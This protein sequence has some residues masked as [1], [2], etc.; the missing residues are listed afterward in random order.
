MTSSSYVWQDRYDSLKTFRHNTRGEPTGQNKPMQANAAAS[1]QT[2]ARDYGRFV[3]AILQGV[4]LKKETRRQMLTPQIRVGESGTN[5]TG[6]PPE[7]LSPTISWGLGWGLQ[8][9]SD[10]LS[11]WHW[12]DNGDSKAYV[13]A[14]AEQRLGVVVLANSAT[15]LSIIREIVDVAVG[16]EQ[17]ALAW[18]NYESH[19]SPARLL[20]KDILAKGAEAALN[21]YRQWRKGRAPR[22]AVNENQMNRVGYDL[23]ALKRIK[24]AIEVFK[25][26]VEDY[27]QSS[28]TY[29]SLGEAYMIAGQKELAIKNYQRSIELNPDNTNGKEMLKKLQETNQD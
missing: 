1:L 29:D 13:V 18:L 2:T 9:T 26:N 7:K 21:E 24:D 22:E 10:G 17:P 5:H 16:G 28:N 20:F 12:G 25:L 6:R 19:K 3:A 27:P 8:E 23:L 11:F 14:F 4:G 15:G